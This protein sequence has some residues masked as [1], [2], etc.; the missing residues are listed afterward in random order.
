MVAEPYTTETAGLS[1][2]LDLID[3]R[4]S[5][6]SMVKAAKRD[7]ARRTFRPDHP[8]LQHGRW[9]NFLL[10]RETP[11]AHVT[12]SIDRRQPSPIGLVGFFE[13]ESEHD[14]ELI[15]DEACR[16]LS[17]NGCTS[18][19]GPINLTMWNSFR[20]PT[21]EIEPPFVTEPFSRSVYAQWFHRAGWT[22]GHRNLTT[23]QVL[24]RT[25]FERFADVAACAGEAGWRFE[26]PAPQRLAALLTAAHAIC[27]ESFRQ[28]WT[29]VPLTPSEF[30]ASYGGLDSR[31]HYPLID[32]CFSP[33]GEPVGF[34]FGLTDPQIP[35]RAVI[36]TLV[37]RPSAQGQGIGRTMLYRFWEQAKSLRIRDV[38][39]S[40]MEASNDA[41]L[42][43]TGSNNRV[44][45]RYET[46]E[47]PLP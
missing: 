40:T 17:E 29:F 28:A 24:E 43:L 20:F 8:F 33:A 30:F 39:F 6:W 14:A 5:A 13:A 4:Y 32:F 19:R 25:G 26:R 37:I 31:A 2:Y 1:G 38:L 3:R 15:I 45:R 35:R 36:K 47:R 34:L 10:R 27:L 7:E 21:D 44:Y 16:W 22:V 12:A 11:V 41:I 23:I 46:F 9:M 42:R 18:V